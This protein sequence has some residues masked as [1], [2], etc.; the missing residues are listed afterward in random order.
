MCSLL[1]HGLQGAVEDGLGCERFGLAAI[2]GGSSVNGACYC[3]TAEGA[4]LYAC[5]YRCPEHTPARLAGEPE[6]DENRYCAP[7]RCYCGSRDCGS[8][9]S[10]ARPLEPI[11]QT[12]V[13]INAIKTG[14]RRAS[15]AE[16]RAAQANTRG[17]AA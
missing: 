7:F 15:L 17:G 10:Y 4:R 13:D 16:Y 6:P 14:K 11:A 9:G 12:V 8:S 1:L 3:G 5:G 2:Q